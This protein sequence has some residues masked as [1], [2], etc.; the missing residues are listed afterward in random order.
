MELKEKLLGLIAAELTEAI[1]DSED[2]AIKAREHEPI[3]LAFL[4]TIAA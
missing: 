3:L 1:K 2:L 4:N